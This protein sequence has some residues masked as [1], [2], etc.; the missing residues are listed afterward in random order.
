MKKFLIFAGVLLTPSLAFAQQ[1]GQLDSL[2]TSFGRIVN[3][4]V[5][6]VFIIALLVFFWG[7]AKYILAAGSEESKAEGR[8]IMVGGIIA[9]FVMASVWGIVRWAQVAIGI[10]PTKTDITVPTIGGRSPTR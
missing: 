3:N 4:M 9:L 1:L 10:D 8:R 2:V 7:L 5:P 6:I